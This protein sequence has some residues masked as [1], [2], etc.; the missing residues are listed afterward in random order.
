MKINLLIILILINS[1]KSNYSITAP[2]KGRFK[3]FIHGLIKVVK[4]VE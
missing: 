4:Q 2:V 3:G 1:I